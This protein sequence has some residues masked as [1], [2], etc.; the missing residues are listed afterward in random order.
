MSSVVTMV[1][2]NPTAWELEDLFD[3]LLIPR[4][5]RT[6]FLT[7][8]GYCADGRGGVSRGIGAR[9]AFFPPPCAT[10]KLK[11]PNHIFLMS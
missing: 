6:I 7:L 1:C 2:K 8:F 3:M 10:Q 4:Q 11:F 9:P 5:Q